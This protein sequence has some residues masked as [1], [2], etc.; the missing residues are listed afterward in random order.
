[1]VVPVS[2]EAQCPF[3]G[4]AVGEY[5]PECWKC[6]ATLSPPNNA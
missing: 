5:D 4:T 3:C 6:E 1:M 2:F